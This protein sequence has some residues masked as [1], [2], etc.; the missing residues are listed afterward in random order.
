MTDHVW[1]VDKSHFDSPTGTATIVSEGFGFMTHKAGGDANDAELNTWW[2]NAKGYRDQIM[3]GAYW[4]L[5]P[6][7]GAGAGDSFV[8]RL[9]SQCSG[10]RDREFILQLDCEIWGGDSSTAPG[11]ADIRA[12]CNRLRVLMPK[13]IPIVY[14][15]KW[16]YGN[17]LT[18]LGFPLW[19][20][21]Y[22]SGSGSASSIYPGDSY[23]GW[24][25]YSG[26]VPTI[27]QFSSTA[28]VAGDST[29]DV[30]AFKGTPADLLAKLAPGWVP[31]PPP[32]EVPQVEL[33]DKV[34]SDPYPNR[35]VGNVLNDVEGVRDFLV[36]DATGTPFS[37]VTATSPLGKLI[38][39]V[40]QIAADVA[41]IKANP[42]TVDTAA[43]ATALAPLIKSMDEAEVQT[44]LEE[45]VR[46][47]VN[48]VPAAAGIPSVTGLPVFDKTEAATRAAREARQ[49]GIAGTGG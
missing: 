29:S 3:L 24:T 37:H 27:A 33:T 4:V 44:A 47:L 41:A 20:S 10:W 48:G 18:G 17:S 49:P 30:N 8:D 25:A 45:A 16:A 31:D 7:H 43:L 36:G 22:V 2:I 6:G 39:Q 40:N 21:S 9:D 34:G 35:T 42:A 28:T 11:L 46:N 32:V 26:I 23:S 12:C 13:L 1:G 38:T 14:A 19:S 15:P 5:Y